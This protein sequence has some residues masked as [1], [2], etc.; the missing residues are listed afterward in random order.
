LV[1][2]KWTYPSPPGRP[3]IDNEQRELVIRLARENP[4]W[5]H[6]RVQ[7]ELTRLGVGLT[8]DHAGSG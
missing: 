3:R 2:K 8:D 1:T 5:G 7:G 4:R 6:R